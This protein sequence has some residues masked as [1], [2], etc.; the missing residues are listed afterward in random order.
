M[1]IMENFY[2]IVRC[3]GVCFPRPVRLI[4]LFHFFFPSLAG[5][6]HEFKQDLN[7]VDRGKK[8]DAVKKV[9]AGMYNR[10]LL[11]TPKY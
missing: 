6:I 8:K 9:I 3:L 1:I 7:A 10:G 11:P 2:S 5:E 4:V